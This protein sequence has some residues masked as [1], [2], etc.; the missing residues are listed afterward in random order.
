MSHDCPQCGQACNCSGDIEDHD[1]GEEFADDCTHHLSD[2]C[3]AQH[4]DEYED[5]DS[6]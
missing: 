4:E 6:I 1:T 3:D 5:E 2:D